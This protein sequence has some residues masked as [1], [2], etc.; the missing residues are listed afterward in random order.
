MQ[1]VNQYSAVR[2]VINNEEYL[3]EDLMLNLFQRGK[4]IR[5]DKNDGGIG[6]TYFFLNLITI[7][8]TNFLISPHRGFVLDKEKWYKDQI[9]KGTLKK[10]VK[11]KFIYGD[12]L[13]RNITDTECTC[14]VIVADSFKK[15]KNTVKSLAEKGLIG[16][17]LIDESDSFITES[18]YRKNLI[19]FEDYTRDVLGEDTP[20][21]TITASP[22]LYQNIDVKIRNTKH[23]QVLNVATTNDEEQAIKNIKELLKKPNEVVIVGANNKRVIYALRDSKTNVL[24]C[25]LMSGV[26]LKRKLAQVV[27]IEEVNKEDANLIILSSNSFAGVDLLE[28]KEDNGSKNAH[29]FLF[30]NRNLP[31]QTLK[32]STIYQFFKRS[33]TGLKSVNYVRIDRKKV[34]PRPIRSK[35]LKTSVTKFVNSTKTSVA[36]KQTKKHKKYHPYVIF[37][38]S[39]GVYTAEVNTDAIDMFEEDCVADNFKTDAYDEFN[40]DRNITFVDN[41]EEQSVTLPAVKSRSKKENLKANIPFIEKYDLFGSDFYFE[42]TQTDSTKSQKQQLNSVLK[43]VR[44]HLMCKDYNGMYMPSIRENRAVILLKNENGEFDDVLNDSLKKNKKY[45]DI[46]YGKRKEKGVS[47]AEKRNKLFEE[48]SIKHIISLIQMCM[49]DK[50]YAPNNYVGSRNYNIPVM[51]SYDVIEYVFSLLY[52][53]TFEFD[54]KNCFARVLY[55]LL[56]KVL[57]SDF[58][59]KNKV[60][61]V[62]INILINDFMYNPS[63]DSNERQQRWVSKEK[64]KKYGFDEDVRDF[65]MENYFDSK[66]RGDI[67][68]FLSYHELKIVLKLKNIMD[69][70]ELNSVGRHDSRLLLIPYE[71]LDEFQKGKQ[72]YLNR[73]VNDMT[74]NGVSGWF[75]MPIY[76]TTNKG[77]F[78]GINEGVKVPKMSRIEKKTVFLDENETRTPLFY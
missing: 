62:A 53:K 9:E 4:T 40:K 56:D 77:D 64:F 19:G 30:E 11:L 5:L 10:G 71:E 21:V 13:D 70:L 34:R 22:L 74:Y 72:N 25:C 65:M 75:D 20:I 29:A 31:E 17:V 55:S 15:Y 57:P 47:V 26:T 60:H 33:R 8:Q 14:V 6:G 36:Q 2:L 76:D 3:P 27:K 42:I 37:D 67:F 45:T 51:M 54:I 49:N 63:S 18:S 7:G 28:R 69:D 58:Y 44:T 46:K 24:R 38:N 32:R 68:N 43:R 48:N 35:C 78:E 41:R 1:E 52:V 73:L 16:K 50:I 12:S 66:F 59:G 39:K 23:N 61:K